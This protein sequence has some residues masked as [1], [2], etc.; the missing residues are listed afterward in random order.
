MCLKFKK[1]KQSFEN[2]L[3]K[4]VGIDKFIS[5]QRCEIKLLYLLVIGWGEALKTAF[6]MITSIITIQIAP[7]IFRVRRKH[8]LFYDNRFLG[9]RISYSGERR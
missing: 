8:L 4:T 2:N 7:A 9:V 3:S 6:L 1:K 5:V